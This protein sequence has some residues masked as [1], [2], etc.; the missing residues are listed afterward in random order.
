MV[1]WSGRRGAAQLPDRADQPLIMAIGSLLQATD[2]YS[3][4]QRL[5]RASIAVRTSAPILGPMASAKASE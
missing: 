4:F 1:R 2:N 5:W 3:L